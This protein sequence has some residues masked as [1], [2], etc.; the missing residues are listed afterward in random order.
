MRNRCLSSPR[1]DGQGLPPSPAKQCPVRGFCLS[2]TLWLKIFSG[3]CSEA[4]CCAYTSCEF[5]VQELN[6]TLVQHQMNVSSFGQ[7]HFMA[8]NFH[9]TYSPS[10]KIQW[11]H[12]KAGTQGVRMPGWASSLGVSPSLQEQPPGPQLSSVALRGTHT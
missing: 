1:C 11:C 2:A 4:H 12:I 3:A 8:S 5:T 7:H 6:R 9:S 10:S